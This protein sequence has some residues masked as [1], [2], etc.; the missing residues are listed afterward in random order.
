MCGQAV[1][2]RGGS[3]NMGHGHGMCRGIARS[4]EVSL[5]GIK[6]GEWARH[7]QRWGAGC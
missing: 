7:M 4:V 5:E 2:G 6:C 3:S 1:E